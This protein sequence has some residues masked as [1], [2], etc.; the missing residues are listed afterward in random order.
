MDTSEHNRT[1][2]TVCDWEATGAKPTQSWFCLLQRETNTESDQ[3][4]RTAAWEISGGFQTGSVDQNPLL[5]VKDNKHGRVR[6]R[7]VSVDSHLRHFTKP[8]LRWYEDSAISSNWLRHYNKAYHISVW[9][10]SCSAGSGL[11]G[12]VEVEQGH[13]LFRFFGIWA[14]VDSRHKRYI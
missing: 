4:S 13:I 2:P 1:T 9:T 3:A 8:Q 7:V 6:S 14:F 12:W 5:I 10:L 11:N